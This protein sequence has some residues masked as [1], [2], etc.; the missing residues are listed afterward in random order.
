MT[1][2][3]VFFGSLFPF[4][5]VIGFI[6]MMTKLKSKNMYCKLPRWKKGLHQAERKQLSISQS[7]DF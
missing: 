6:P 7:I 2:C 1:L 3:G 4:Q 5:A